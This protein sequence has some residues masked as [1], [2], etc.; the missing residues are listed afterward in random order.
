MKCHQLFGC[1]ILPPDPNPNFAF[2]SWLYLFFHTRLLVSAAISSNRI[3]QKIEEKKC[4]WRERNLS[5]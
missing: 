1:D 2:K 5:I 3:A 4:V